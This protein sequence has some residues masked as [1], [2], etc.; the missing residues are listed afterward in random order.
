MVVIVVS[1]PWTVRNM[2][3]H[4]TSATVATESN[5]CPCRAIPESK[6]AADGPHLKIAQNHQSIVMLPEIM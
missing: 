3:V 2:R 4:S 1:L 6:S 5:I